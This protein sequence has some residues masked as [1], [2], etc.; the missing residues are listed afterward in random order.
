MGYSETFERCFENTLQFEGE[1][2]NHP[3]DSGGPTMYG[4]AWNYNRAFYFSLGIDSPEKVK[5][6][7][8]DQAK[9][10]YHEKYFVPAKCSIFD[11]WP[12]FCKS[13]FD[14]ALHQGVGGAVKTLQYM[15]NLAS[16]SEPL[17]I[18]GGFGPATEAKVEKIF[19]GDWPD[20]GF[21]DENL[22]ELFE[23]ARVDFYSARFRDPS[24]SW[25]MN[26]RFLNSGLRRL[27]ERR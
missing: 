15:L 24:N 21:N 27:I 1:Y 8:K 11:R 7:T 25:Y 23:A 10:C 5:N 6:L 26:Y 3:K 13:Y 2:Y 4:V 18:D 14:M 16:P 12:I 9:K 22:T 20:F 19:S 17:K